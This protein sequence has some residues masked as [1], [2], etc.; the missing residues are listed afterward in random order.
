MDNTEDTIHQN[1]IDECREIVHKTINENLNKYI[2]NCFQEQKSHSIII[3]DK[4]AQW[5]NIVGNS[6][7]DLEYSIYSLENQG[8][9]IQKYNKFDNESK[10]EVKVGYTVKIPKSRNNRH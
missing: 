10:T 4:D 7:D 6:N 3:N 1:L 2:K 8:F 5:L 9:I